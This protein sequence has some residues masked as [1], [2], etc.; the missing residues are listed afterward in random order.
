MNYFDKNLFPCS[1]FTANI[2]AE[3]IGV[4]HIKITV[5]YTKSK[6]TFEYALKYF[7]ELK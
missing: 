4:V 7:L 5:L 2:T 1:L 3:Q 6:N